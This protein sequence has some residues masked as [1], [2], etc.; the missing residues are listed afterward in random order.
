MKRGFY[1]GVALITLTLFGIIS[2]QNDIPEPIYIVDGQEM[3]ISEIDRKGI[4]IKHI[5]KYIGELAI[6]KFGAKGKHGVMV[7]S[8]R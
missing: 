4:I 8:T 6:E 1:L 5:D 3:T 7:I 2:L